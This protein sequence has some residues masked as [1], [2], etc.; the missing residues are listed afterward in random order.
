MSELHKIISLAIPAMP[1]VVTG[2]WAYILCVDA[3]GE[4]RWLFAFIDLCAAVFVVQVM[5]A[6]VKVGAGK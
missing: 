3:I 5:V 1:L 2:L 6:I 4:R